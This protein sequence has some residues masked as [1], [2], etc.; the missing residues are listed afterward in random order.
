[1]N[2]KSVKRGIEKIKKNETEQ[3]ENEGTEKTKEMK[4]RK[5]DTEKVEKEINIEHFQRKRENERRYKRN[6]EKER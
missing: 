2:G 4:R 6:S 5:E 3:K 1:M